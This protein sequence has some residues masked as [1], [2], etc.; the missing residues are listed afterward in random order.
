MLA[1]MLDAGLDHPPNLRLVLLGGA[2]ITPEL[3][4]RA[5]VA[6]VP[7]AGT[8]GM[9]EACSQVF[10]AGAPLFCTDVALRG[11]LAGT[12]GPREDPARA[13]E[14]LVRGPTL[15]SASVATMGGSRPVIAAPERPTAPCA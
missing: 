13:E 5:E 9:T 6:G 12:R 15:A 11:E 4:A 14:I 2:P 7:V 8:Y 10:T 3:L 1:R